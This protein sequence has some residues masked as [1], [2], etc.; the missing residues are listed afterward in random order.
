MRPLETITLLLLFG[1]LLG[2]WFGRR[3]RWLLLL[4]WLAALVALAH[5]LREGYRWQMLPAYVALVVLLLWSLSRLAS[6]AARP[7]RWR[8]HLAGSIVLLALIFAALLAYAFPV[9]TLP[10]AGGPYLVGTISFSLRDASRLELY[11]DAPDDVRETMVQFWYPAVPGPDDKKAALIEHLDIAAPALAQRLGLPSFLFGHLNL[12]D[13]GVYQDAL[14]ARDGAPYP[15]LVFSH[16]LRGL[17]VQNSVLLRELASH[18]Y[19]VASIDHTYG[20]IL[21][22]FP[23]GRAVFYD[24]DR[25]FPEGETTIAGGSRLV[26][27]WAADVRFLLHEAATWR[28]GGNGLAGLLDLQQLG[29]LGHSTGAAAAIEV[30]AAEPSCGAVVTLDG[31]IEPVDDSIVASGPGAPLLSLRAPAWLGPQNAAR[32]RELHQSS[33]ESAYLVTI[34]GTEHFDYTDIPLFSPFTS[35]LGLS[36]EN[37]ADVVLATI[38]DYTRAFFDWHLQ[39]ERAAWEALDHE[40]VL[41]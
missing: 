19:V 32:G 22:V 35:R 27:T 33:G 6:R 2:L 20:N 14:P 10:P 24:G 9:V 38:N 13:T 31:W 40:V 17:R 7:G 26:D 21:T 1:A 3:H 5:V 29:T 15:L 8:R 4:P 37:D 23:D 34:P 18:G 41:D 12:I 11:S 28:E 39:G 30:C 16:G 25:V 36:G